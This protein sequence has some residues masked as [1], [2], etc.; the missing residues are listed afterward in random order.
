MVSDFLNQILRSFIGTFQVCSFFIFDSFK[1]RGALCALLRLPLDKRKIGVVVAS[2]GNEAISMCFHAGKYGVPVIAVMPTYVPIS[3]M[4]RCHA[5]GA[6]VIVEG[7]TLFDAQ[8]HAR[9]LARDK[10]LTYINGYVLKIIKDL[11]R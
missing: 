3:Y 10:G 1:E 4:Q 11:S 9:A 8:K 6:K 2:L 7:S 5:M